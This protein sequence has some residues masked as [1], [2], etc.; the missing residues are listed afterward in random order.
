[1]I[2][3]STNYDAVTSTLYQYAATLSARLGAGHVHLT[4][5][6]AVVKATLTSQPNTTM[7]F[8]GHGLTPP[9]VGMLANDGLPAVELGSVAL[10]SRR[11]VAGTCCH[12][13]RLGALAAPNGFTLF[14]YKDL[15]RVP[16]TAPYVGDMQ[17]AAL[18]GPAVIAKGGS[19][20]S[21]ARA[22][23]AEYSRRA[24]ILFARNLPGDRVVALI[25][26]LNASRV[27]AW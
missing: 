15:L 26:G 13:D 25:F 6:A 23:T 11:T 8:F 22:A 7:L 12:G 19:S 21:A 27:G 10:L 1:M 16:T 2:L 4:S 18:A 14:G 17:P 5:P 9:G 24:Q 20:A 3:V